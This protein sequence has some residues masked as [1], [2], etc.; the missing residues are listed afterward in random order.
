[1]SDVFKLPEQLIIN[2]AEELY[3]KLSQLM[4]S[5]DEVKLDI[6]DVGKADTACLQLLCVVQKSLSEIG[7][8]IK[9][10][11][12]SEALKSTANIVGVANFLQL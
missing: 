10:Q 11:G 5:G 6:S 12:D 2:Q 8:K 9:W 7:H 4:E 1:M 3:A